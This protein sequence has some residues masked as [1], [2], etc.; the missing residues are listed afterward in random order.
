[1]NWKFT[2]IYVICFD[3][4]FSGAGQ[5]YGPSTKGGLFFLGR[6]MQEHPSFKGYSS[7]LLNRNL[8]KQV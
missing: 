3:L 7:S 8:S 1:M 4:F 2:R 6:C 5:S